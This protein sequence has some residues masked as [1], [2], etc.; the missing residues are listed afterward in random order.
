MCE[1]KTEMRF[2]H[3]TAHHF[4][5]RHLQFSQ[6]WSGL[7]ISSSPISRKWQFTFSPL[8]PSHPIPITATCTLGCGWAHV[9]PKKALALLLALQRRWDTGRSTV[10]AEP[11]ANTAGAA[12]AQRKRRMPE[13]T[14]PSYGHA[15]YSNHAGLQHLHW[16]CDFPMNI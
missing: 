5:T 3:L 4:W 8:L 2:P 7:H 10:L 15:R 16:R 12:P 1:E 14:L 9:P 11:T 6:D 13:H